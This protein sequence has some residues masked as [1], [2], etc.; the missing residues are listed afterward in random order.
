MKQAAQLAAAFLALAGCRGTPDIAMKEI[1][2][3]P[4]SSKAMLMHHRDSWDALYQR[5]DLATGRTLP[6]TLSYAVFTG[7]FE[8]DSSRVTPAL[9]QELGIE[10]IAFGS[11]KGGYNGYLMVP[12]D[13]ALVGI[14][15]P[16]TNGIGS[17]VDV[18]CFTGAAPVFHLAAGKV[19]ML[20]SANRKNERVEKGDAYDPAVAAK[21]AKLARFL[22]DGYPGITAETQLAPVVAKIQFSVGD[23]PQSTYNP[24]PVGGLFRPAP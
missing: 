18:R 2:F 7:L 22:A 8:I 12:G 1:T 14:V 6:E 11:F 13:Y 19:S 23:T 10:D 15:Q 3:G 17:W 16:N 24:C 4:D 9:K 5:V 20:E 21:D